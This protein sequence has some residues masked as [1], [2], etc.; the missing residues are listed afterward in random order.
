MTG[1]AW[2]LI[3]PTTSN[4]MTGLPKKRFQSRPLVLRKTLVCIRVYHLTTGVMRVVIRWVALPV[5]LAIAAT[6]ISE[7]SHR[8]GNSDVRANPDCIPG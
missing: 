6:Y 5:K 1:R 3:R 4:K 2:P 7:E 8:Y